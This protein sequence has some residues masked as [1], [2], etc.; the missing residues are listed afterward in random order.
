[1]HQ[2]DKPERVLDSMFEI[3]TFKIFIIRIND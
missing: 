3:V 1:M 2:R